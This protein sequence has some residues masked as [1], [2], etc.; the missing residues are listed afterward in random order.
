MG[1]C[2]QRHYHLHDDGDGRGDFDDV[3]ACGHDL[4][5]CVHQ[6]SMYAFD[7]FEYDLTGHEHEIID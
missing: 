3:C 1:E 5:P 6:I 2:Q 7:V 4:G